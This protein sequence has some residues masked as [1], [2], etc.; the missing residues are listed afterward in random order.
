VASRDPGAK[1]P[2][3][4]TAGRAGARARWGPPRVLRLDTLTQEQRRLV[5]ALVDA[6]RSA[7]A[8]ADAPPD[9]AA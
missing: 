9:R 2:V 8:D 1:N 4:I 3:F 5:M 7:P 6:A